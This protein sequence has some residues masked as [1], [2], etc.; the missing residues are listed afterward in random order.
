MCQLK[1]TQQIATPE[2]SVRRLAHMPAVL[3][4]S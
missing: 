1:L 3:Q 2:C 4:T